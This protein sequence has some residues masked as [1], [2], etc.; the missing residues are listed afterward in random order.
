MILD[1][2]SLCIQF[3]P[4]QEYELKRINELSNM[5]EIAEHFETIPPVSMEA[6]Q[7]LW[8]YI[9]SGIV[10]LWGIHE[11]DRIIGGAGFYTQ[12]PGTRLSH[13][14]TFFLYLEPASW[15]KGIGRKSI[16]FLEEEVKKRGYIR[17]ECMV[18][19]SNP[20]AIRLYER[21]GY[22]QEGIKKQAFLIDGAYKDLI[23]MGK[24]FLN[25]DAV[26]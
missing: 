15:G 9:Q 24:L 14:A 3:C 10:S 6:T 26:R 8:N 2:S 17:M 20:R 22:E 19:D 16:Q 1:N 12:P 4:L 25:P 18:A 21:L 23:I 7:A 13:V 5:P 11:K